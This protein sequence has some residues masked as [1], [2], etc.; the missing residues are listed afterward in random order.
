M[1]GQSL[2][3]LEQFGYVT[4]V[5]LLGEFGCVSRKFGCLRRVWL[6]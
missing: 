3:M 2:A 1:L 5:C 6:D 4:R